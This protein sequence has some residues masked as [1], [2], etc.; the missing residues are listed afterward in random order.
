MPLVHVQPWVGPESDE[1]YST[2]DELVTVLRADPLSFRTLPGFLRTITRLRD[3]RELEFRGVVLTLPAGEAPGGDWER[4]LR[5]RFGDAIL[6]SSIPWDD[7]VSEALMARRPVVLA[8][9]ES[10][11]AERYRALAGDLGLSP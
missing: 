11:A 4:S 9:P 2:A 8:A 6:P 1:I 10:A 7:A 3:E 5:G